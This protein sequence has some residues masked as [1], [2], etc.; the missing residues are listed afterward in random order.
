LR[1][2]VDSDS[3]APTRVR[4]RELALEQV[5][6]AVEVQR[7]E[8]YIEFLK[9]KAQFADKE[10]LDL[11]RFESGFESQAKPAQETATK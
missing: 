11:S 10:K 5:R 1:T 8:N 6:L 7:L 2:A 9:L 4:D 3:E